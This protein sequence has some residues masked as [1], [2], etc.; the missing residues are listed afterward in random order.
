MFIKHLNVPDTVKGAGEEKICKT[1]LSLRAQFSGKHRQVNTFMKTHFDNCYNLKRTNWN[2]E[3]TDI[4]CNF[5][6]KERY[7]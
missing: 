1:V 6:C 4:H 7:N 2:P 3:K 5:S